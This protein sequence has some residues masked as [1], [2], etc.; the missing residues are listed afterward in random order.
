M[1][2]IKTNIPTLFDEFNTLNSLFDSR[3]TRQGDFRPAIDVY[4]SGEAYVITAELPGVDEKNI[5]IE[6][7]DSVLT[8]K[9]ER[10]TDNNDKNTYHRKEIMSGT[11]SRSMRFST[12][13]D[14]TK[15]VASCKNGLLEIRLPKEEALKP[16]KIQV[17]VA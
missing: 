5:D 4:D 11:F 14:A 8:L 12:P 15:I 3:S 6:Y 13:I 10:K 1:F 9:A 2:A 7:S 17:S 16:R